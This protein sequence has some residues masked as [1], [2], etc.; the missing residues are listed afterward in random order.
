MIPSDDKRDRLGAAS[1]GEIAKRL[2]IL[3]AV[4]TLVFAIFF[5]RLFQLQLILSDDLRLRS[6]RNYVRSVRLEAPRGDI[7]DREGRV[8][9]TTRPAFGVG[10]VPN[11]LRDS[12]RTLDVLAALIDADAEHLRERVG[13]PRGRR[14]FQRVRV[15][16]DLD[17]DQRV[18]VESHLF[19]L[20]GVVTDV[21]P[22]RHYLA[23]DV[24]AHVLGYLGEIQREQLASRDY[25]GYRSGE[26]VGQA[27]IEA[28]EQGVLRGRAGG[29]NLVVDVAGRVV[30]PP[31]DEIEPTSGGKVQLTIDLDLQAAA[32]EAFLP[33]VI[34]ERGH[35]GAL[36]ALDVRT[37]EVLAM[38]SRPAFDPN[39]FAGGV[40]SE[41]WD[42]LVAD[43]WRPIQN[44]VISGQYP[45][46][47]TYKAIVAAAALEDGLAPAEREL[48]CPGFYR[49]GSRSYRC[50]KPA[51][52]GWVN[53]EK[54]LAE[55]CDVYFY[56]L[57]TELG[58]DRIAFFARG[59]GLG[60]PSGLRLP[61]E[62]PGLVPTEAWKERRFRE[63]WLSGET[64][65]ASIGQGFNLVTPLQIAVTYAAIANGGILL[66]P[67]LLLDA[68]EGAFGVRPEAI[69]RVPVSDSNLAFLRSALESAVQ[70]DS[71]TGARAR[72]P[73]VRV[74][75]K[76]GTAQVVGLRHTEDLE[77]DEVKLRHRDHA[78]FVGFAPVEAPEIVVAAILEH[79]GH[80]GSAAAPL[81]QRVLNVY[82]AKQRQREEAPEETTAVAPTATDTRGGLDVVDG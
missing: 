67:R 24:A 34:G 2:P 60:R 72:V 44:R 40:Q 64:V 12:A 51:G 81:V 73:G 37:G 36:V 5:L 56:E 9:V 41:I 50:W 74:G 30:G 14:R 70:G 55:S 32:E 21:Q 45:P 80:G 26:F 16:T 3:A 59:L 7:L 76:T 31:L 82:F 62:Q 66:R 13:A 43:E 20:P 18:R 17:Y 29:R 48:F 11:E 58:I 61:H 38:V 28:L 79:S 19:G 57:G 77:D 53:L 69:G 42:A 68:G 33:D 49:H 10:V 52:H 71:G 23:G 75:G 22:R 78:W 47:S 39:D 8:L 1:E 27:G 65:S 46:G 4:M 25:A 35:S 6:E 63:P 15:A 54:A